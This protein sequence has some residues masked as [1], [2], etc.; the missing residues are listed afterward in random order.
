M[1]CISRSACFKGRTLKLERPKV[2]EKTEACLRGLEARDVG[3]MK[4]N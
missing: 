2:G 4:V 1:L 3:V